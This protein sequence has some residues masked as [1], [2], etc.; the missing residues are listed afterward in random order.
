MAQDLEVIEEDDGVHIRG[1]LN[2]I[3]AI[4]E[5]QSRVMYE[6]GTTSFGEICENDQPC[7]DM[8]FEEYLNQQGELEFYDRNMT[9][10]GVWIRET[11]SVREM[12]F[13]ISPHDGGN[14]DTVIAIQYSRFG[15]IDIVQPDPFT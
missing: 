11:G 13:R 15:E 6:A 10:M 3:R 5:N 4:L 14:I 9:V 7:R 8:I 12:R 2:H 1:R